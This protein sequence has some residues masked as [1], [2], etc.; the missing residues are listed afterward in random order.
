[1]GYY[2]YCQLLDKNN[3]P[4]DSLNL[5]DHFVSEYY[6]ETLYEESGD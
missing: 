5:K 1:M 3:I 2:H 4:I 6:G